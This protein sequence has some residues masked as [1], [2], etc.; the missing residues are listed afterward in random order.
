MT[1]PLLASLA[2]VA[3]PEPA[4]PEIA[5]QQFTL[6]NGLHVILH[7]D[8]TAPVVGVDM[9]YDVGSKDERPGR[10]GFAHLFEHLMFQ[11]TAQLPKGEA[12]RLIE[13]AGGSANGATSTDRTQY[14]EQVPTNALEQVLFIQSER[15]GFLLPTLDQAKL[16]NQRD[17]VRNERR[18]SYEMQ[19]YG[20]AMKRVLENLWDPA[21]PYHWMT[22]GSHEDLEAATLDDVRAF[23]KR[24]Y[25]PR[26][27]SLSIAG[28]ID[29]ARVRALVEKWFA[30][31][32]PS[33]ALER[34]LPSPKPLASEKR[35]EMR[36]RVQLP[37]SYLAWQSPKDYAEDDAALSILGEVLSAGKS[38]RLQKRLVMDER[39]AQSVAAV[40]HG[41]SLA[42]MFLVVVTA[43]PGEPL[44]RL[45]REI[46]EEMARLS[47]EPPSGEEVQRAK[48][49]IESQAIFGLEPVGGFG[50]RAAA[51]NGYWME[52]R[53]P[54]YLAKDLARFLAV[55]PEQVSAAAR[56]W[57]RPDKRVVLRVLPVEG[58]EPAAAGGKEPG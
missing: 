7:E 13:A 1:L 6:P 15:M 51:L 28:D 43:K 30:D 26:N 47:R 48:N 49:R 20:L 2:L 55:T 19:P 58:G 56:R 35:V 50:G 25:G 4:V 24:F 22:I 5:F 14:W 17:V 27:A 53:D 8:H 45:E 36:D 33:E 41:Q 9:L 38:A 16:D 54:G 44:S 29:P 39:I 42:G 11:G 23:F 34:D 32:P 46:D 57:L 10:T 12:D 21:F 37:R 52:T 40:Q 3:G 18:Q 31:V